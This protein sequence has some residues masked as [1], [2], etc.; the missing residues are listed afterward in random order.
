LADVLIAMD[1][2][3]EVLTGSTRLKAGSATKAALNAVSTAAMVRAG[4]VFENLMVDLRQGSA[5]LRDRALRIVVTAT[6]AEREDAEAAL[7]AARGE[8]KVA[9]VAL[10]LG[11]GTAQARRRL[12]AAGGFVRAA[13]SS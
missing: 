11:L 2:G 4:K 10:R 3:P 1:T 13:L 7:R 6:G 12:A 9:I 8:V 5:K